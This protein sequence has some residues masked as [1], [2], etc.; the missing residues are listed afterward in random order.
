MRAQEALR[1]SHD[2]LEERV[3]ERTKDLTLANLKLQEENEKQQISIDIAKKMLFMINGAPPAN[4]A[5]SKERMLCV[6]A[7]TLPCNMEGGDHLFVRKTEGGTSKTFG[8]TVISLKDQSGH[9]VGCILRSILTDLLHNELLNLNP[10]LPVE[11]GIARLNEKVMNSGIMDGDDFFTGIFGEIDNRTLLFRYVSAGH[12]PFLLIRGKNVFLYPDETGKGSNLP[13]ALTCGISFNAGEITLQTRDKLLF[14][15]DGLTEMPLAKKGKM[16]S[17]EELAEIAKTI[18]NSKEHE[19]FLV[20]IIEDIIS[21]IAE[22]SEESVLLDDPEKGRTNTSSDDI[23]FLGIEVEDDSLYQK[24]SIRAMDPKALSE[25]INTLYEKIV[26][27][28]YIHGYGEP[29]NRLRMVL[30]EAVINAWKHGNQCDPE[31]AVEVFWRCGNDFHLCIV[32]QGKGF[33]ITRIPDPTLHENRIKQNGRGVFIIRYLAEKAVWDKDGTRLCLLFRKKWSKTDHPSS[34]RQNIIHM[35]KNMVFAKQKDNHM[36]ILVFQDDDKARFEIRGKI[37]EKGA[38]ELKSRFRELNTSRM[39]EVVFDFKN[40]SHIGS[41]GIG[42]LLLFYKD[43]AT[44]GGKISVINTSSS[45]HELFKVLRL[46][47]IFTV[48]PA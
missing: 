40:V 17:K 2:E 46:D 19:P 36:E 22:K 48:Q 28:W 13:M 10:D 24:F 25:Q 21:V 4:I 7:F 14:Y 23:S 6:S 32:D 31:K 15:T 9:E 43:M 35:L 11:Q 20:E 38:D 3:K 44:H 26:H 39:S 18:C 37:D 12:P 33:D 30:E 41:A 45:V 27:L 8:K 16:I 47:S 1:R 34:R 5:L 42:K 29:E